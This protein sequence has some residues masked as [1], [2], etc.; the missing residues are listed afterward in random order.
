MSE[1]NIST[2]TKVLVAVFSIISYFIVGRICNEFDSILVS[3]IVP[4][5]Y[6]TILIYIVSESSSKVKLT[7]LNLAVLAVGVI[8][9]YS[10]PYEMVAGIA[11]LM[12]V[13]TLVIIL[14]AAL[15][16]KSKYFNK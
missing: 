12:T 3:M 6:V 1:N 16:R 5:L 13:A 2:G 14:V 7:L 11:L 10:T 15:S 4:A 8:F 9:M